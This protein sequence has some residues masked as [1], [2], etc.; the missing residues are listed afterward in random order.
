M[1]IFANSRN[2]LTAVVEV[3]NPITDLLTQPAFLAPR[4]RLQD[5]DP[6]DRQVT[7]D[8]SRFWASLS[9]NE[10]LDANA[11]WV[12]ADLSGIVDPFTEI[13]DGTLLRVPSIERYQFKILDPGELNA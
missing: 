2:Q 7:A 1:T 11:W 12:I 6:T 10:L 13:P 5:F 9:F 3:V 8:G 4:D